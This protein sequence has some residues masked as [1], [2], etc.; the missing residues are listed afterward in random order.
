MK[1]YRKDFRGA[2]LGCFLLLIIV[3]MISS[4]SA[5]TGS[6]GNGR[7][8]LRPDVGEE[9][10]KY[11][12]VINTNDVG[13]EI[14]V[15][16]SGDLAEDI[17]VVDDSFY[18]AP[19]EEKKA[20]FIIDVKKGGKTESKINI[21]FTPT[22]GGNGVGLSSTVIVIAEGEDEE[23]FGLSLFGNGNSESESNVLTGSVVN[24]VTDKVSGS[25]SKKNLFVVISSLMTLAFLVVLLVLVGFQSR[26]KPKKNVQRDE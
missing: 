2:V 25:F 26:I 19:G 12:R 23:G 21:K 3:G 13:V 1:D 15:F 9:V 18:L 5:I 24:S 8:I 7:M 22:D 10:E 16:A 6:I 17:E 14:E 20:Y 4:V 11:V